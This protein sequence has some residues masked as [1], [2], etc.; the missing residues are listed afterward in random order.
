MTET[1]EWIPLMMK[2][3][4]AVMS[5]TERM[6]SKKASRIEAAVVTAIMLGA[7]TGGTVGGTDGD[8]GVGTTGAGPR[9]GIP[10]DGLGGLPGEGDILAGD[11]ARRALFRTDTSAP[12]EKIAEGP[13]A[14]YGWT[15]SC[16]RMQWSD[17]D[18][19]AVDLEQG[20]PGRGARPVRPRLAGGEGDAVPIA[21]RLF[22]DLV[23]RERVVVR[24][25]Q[26]HRQRRGAGLGADAGSRSAVEIPSPGLLPRAS[27]GKSGPDMSERSSV[28]MQSFRP[29]SVVEH[30]PPRAR[31]SRNARG[32]GR[33]R[34]VHL[35]PQPHLARHP[36]SINSCGRSAGLA[37][38]LGYTGEVNVQGEEVQKLDAFSNETMLR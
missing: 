29:P 26:R 31:P 11:P 24:H 34:R 10:A 20:L 13:G 15:A 23:R 7:C 4:R 6:M 22:T 3:P 35:A 17:A 33:D 1:L 37:D 32:S 8:G 28:N 5:S 27:S 25:G 16:K 18:L 14:I 19:P 12:V 2:S 30:A 9:A 21:R 36:P 38:L